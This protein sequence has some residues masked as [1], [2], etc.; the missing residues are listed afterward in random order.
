MADLV[1]QCME[2]DPAARPSA[3]DIVDLLTQPDSVLD[4]HLAPRFK[5]SAEP[6]N[7]VPWDRLTLENHCVLKHTGAASS[8]CTRPPVS[9]QLRAFVPP[10]AA[11]IA[12]FECCGPA[13]IR[14]RGTHR[15]SSLSLRLQAQ[16]VPPAS[17]SDVHS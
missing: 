9:A 11:E 13:R 16:S 5:T 2:A 12:R 4:R 10:S 14:S 6:G 17:L 8:M 7:K 3:R 15:Q 1:A